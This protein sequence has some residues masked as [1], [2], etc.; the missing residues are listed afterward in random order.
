[1]KRAPAQRC[2]PGLFCLFPAS[3]AG[4]RCLR[5]EIYEAPRLGAPNGLNSEA[6]ASLRCNYDTTLIV[7]QQGCRLSDI[8][9]EPIDEVKVAGLLCVNARPA[10]RLQDR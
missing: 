5:P 2:D 6:S 10:D 7:G 1:M 3:P 8:L 9:P 4:G